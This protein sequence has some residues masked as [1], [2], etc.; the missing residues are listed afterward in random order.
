MAAVAPSDVTVH[1]FGETGTGKEKVARALHDRSRRARG[2][3]VAINASS[4]GDEMFQDEL[5]GHTRGA[6]T[7]A[8]NV[9]DGLVAAAEGG[10]L[11]I[12]EVIDLSVLAQARLLRLLQEREYRRGGEN[13][14]RH[15]N[16]RILTASNVAL[17]ERVASGRFRSD[18]LYRLN[19]EVLTLPPLRDRGDDVLALARHFVA[20]AAAREGVP[21]PSLAAEVARAVAAYSWPGNIRE[22]ESQMSRLVRRGGKGP[23]RAEHLSPELKSPLARPR[24]SLKEAALVHERGHVAE[25]LARNGGNRARTALDLGLTRQALVVKIRRLG[26]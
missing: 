11:F 8:V 17:E 10:T 7:G 16:V 1:I 12:D 5:F 23:I 6:F 25:A 14:I 4:Y 19:V 21:V 18:L 13:D 22:L 20:Q 15:A 9:R 2:P 3:F 24:S 26:L